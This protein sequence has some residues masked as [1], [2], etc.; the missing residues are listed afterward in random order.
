MGWARTSGRSARPD[1]PSGTASAGSV[2]TEATMWGIPTAQ[3]W[4]RRLLS[5]LGWMRPALEWRCPQCARPLER[6]HPPGCLLHAELV[7]YRCLHC[8]EEIP[9]WGETVE[10]PKHFMLTER[11]ELRD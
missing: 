4:A 1:L 9:F 6:I 2:R 5:A 11:G 7:I 3:S 10:P 8:R